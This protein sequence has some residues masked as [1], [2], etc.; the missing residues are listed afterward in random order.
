MEPCHVFPS[1]VFPARFSSTTLRQRPAGKTKRVTIR[2]APFVW[3]CDDHSC[4]DLISDTEFVSVHLIDRPTPVLQTIKV[5]ASDAQ[6]SSKPPDSFGCGW[7][8]RSQ[9]GVRLIFRRVSACFVLNVIADKCA[10]PLTSPQ[11]TRVPRERLPADK[12]A[13]LGTR[14]HLSHSGVPVFNQSAM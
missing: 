12:P 8:N 5:C 1:G 13:A 10:W 2:A 7:R 6:F 3:H 11:K 14:R 4:E 9:A